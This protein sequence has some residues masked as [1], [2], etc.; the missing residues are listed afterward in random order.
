MAEGGKTTLSLAYYRVDG[1]LEAKKTPLSY[2]QVM[3]YMPGMSFT[4]INE[5][6][7]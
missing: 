3:F 2:I 4:I 6:K 1:V 5:N 7:I